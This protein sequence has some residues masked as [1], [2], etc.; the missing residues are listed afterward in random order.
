M[1]RLFT[2]KQFSC[3]LI[4]FIIATCY[5]ACTKTG[6]KPAVKNT[7]VTIS[8]IS[9]NSGTY[10]TVVVITG[11]G[12]D[13]ARANDK[14]LFNGKLAT[15]S[16]AT[17]TQL[18]VAVP[19]DAGTGNITLSVNDGAPVSGPVFTYNTPATISSISV[20]TGAYNTTVII[21]GT[22]FDI[23]LAN[24]KVSFNGKAATVSAATAT[25]LTVT[26]PL[27]AGTGNITLSVNN[28]ASVSGPVFTYQFTP[29]VTMLAGTGSQGSTNGTGTSAAFNYPTGVA[30]DAAGNVYVADYGNNL[31]RRI[32]AAGVVTTLAGSGNQ[33]LADGTGASA[34]FIFPYGVAADAAG[35]VYVADYGNNAIRRVTAAG[36][37]TTLAGSGISGSTNGTGAAASFRGP[38]SVAVDAAGNV[39]VA[40]VHNNLIRKISTAGVVT[41]LAG[42]GTSGSTNGTGTSAS[43]NYPAG[44]AV[45]AAGNVYVADSGNNLIRKITASG[46]VTTFA[47]NGTAGSVNGT[48][49]SASFNNPAGLAIDPSGNVYV[50]D[51]LN[52]L[53][54][55]ITA[56]GV[57]TT[58]A[59]SGTQGSVNGAGASASFKGPAS[60]AVD[61]AGNVYV[62][63]FYNQLI[64]EITL[65]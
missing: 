47:G 44:V 24:D 60:V 62:A 10:N 50:A 8:A 34:S 13:T 46:V 53:I 32:T 42:S 51:Y 36:V 23:T 27:G 2:K 59:G 26:V 25:Q 40:D 58:F 20:N 28:T 17:T 57:V 11:T 1:I 22:G 31:I 56:A 38:T 65:K 55:K 54:R 7:P 45:D 33:A 19:L 5:L 63:D 6:T 37:V 61:A 41:T 21:T 52:N 4:L 14:V 12:F 15:V 9:V 3:A 16:A 35:N 43:F 30:A 48:G 39:Y 29:V 18:T 49:I 64:R